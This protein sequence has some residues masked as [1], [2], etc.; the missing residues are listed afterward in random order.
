MTRNF[1]ISSRE[2]QPQQQLQNYNSRW[3]PHWCHT[4]AAWWVWPCIIRSILASSGRHD[5]HGQQPVAEQLNLPDRVMI[6]G[7]PWLMTC[8][9]S[10]K[11]L[12]GFWKTGVNGPT[13][14]PTQNFLC[15]RVRWRGANVAR[16]LRAM[17][18]QKYI[19]IP[20][21]KYIFIYVHMYVYICVY[22]YNGWV[23]ALCCLVIKMDE[24]RYYAVLSSKWMTTGTMLSCH[25]NGWVPAMCWLVIKMDE[26]RSYAGLSNK[27]MTTG[28]ILACH[29]NG[30][31][32]VLCWPVFKMD[33]YRSY[34]GLS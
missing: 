5:D 8:Q 18:L 24:Y 19:N 14:I 34:A 15:Y 33:E 10:G 31:V 23:P 1:A 4:G 29:K 21:E 2:G 12:R 32:P 20:S 22:T 13:A 6:W 17:P 7:I 30:W 28:L 27:W 25:K 11:Q 16:F 9:T 3:V 26:Y